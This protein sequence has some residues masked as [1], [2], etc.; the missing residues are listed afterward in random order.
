MIGTLHETLYYLGQLPDW[1]HCVFYKTSATDHLPTTPIESWRAVYHST[2]FDLIQVNDRHSHHHSRWCKGSGSGRPCVPT[3]VDL[4]TVP[5]QTLTQALVFLRCC[6]CPC[7]SHS[8]RVFAGV[9]GYAVR[10][11]APRPVDT[12]NCAV[13]DLSLIHI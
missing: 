8:A 2:T 13:L 4:S 9:V 1:F 3:Q 6:S 11:E 7:C 12:A 10:D 5:T